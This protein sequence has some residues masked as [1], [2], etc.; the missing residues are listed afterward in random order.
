[1]SSSAKERIP[2]LSKSRFMAGLQCHK[3]LY[4]ECY[5]RDLADP[6]SAQQQSLFDTG[7]EVGTLARKLYPGGVL[8][9][10]DYFNHSAAVESTKT[11]L[12]DHKIPA[13]Y[14]AA[15]KYDNIR[16]R[17]DILVRA[18]SD[19]FDLVEI[20]SGTQTKEEHVPD[21]AVQL[22]VLN[23]CGINIRRTCL[24]H[25]NRDYTYQGGD[26][27][28]DQ[29][30]SLDDI[31]G[32]AQ[33]MQS[34]IPL[35]L[36]EMRT[37]LWGMEPPDIDTGRQCAHPYTCSF[38]GHCHANEPE[39]H[40]SQLPRACQGL[41]RT[42]KEAGIEDIR[43]IP[44]NFVE[45]TA[46]QKRVQDCVVH[47]RFYLDRQLPLA[48]QQLDYPIHFLDFETLSP[49][50]P[51]Y[52]GTRPY[53]V[54]P[55]QWSD[56]ILERDEN[57]RH[58]EFLHEGT[59]DPREAFTTSLLNVLGSEGSI[60]VY[61]GFE[62][63]RIRELADTFPKLANELLSLEE[64]RIVD[65]LQLIRRYCYHKEFHGSFS[66]KSVLPALVPGMSYDDLEINDGGMAPIAYAEMIHPD[67]LSERRN[68]LK[69]SLLAYCSRDT[70]A[71]VQLFKKLQRAFSLF[72]SFSSSRPDS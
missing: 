43:D 42:L 72:P 70:E 33:K 4:F 50:L 62:A 69:R 66:I 13:L 14:E 61:S 1:M 8:I 2:L 44:N 51:L 52:I 6:V 32:E 57:L 31:T 47:N 37:P 24:G 65:L 16:I 68:F 7:T 36:T 11:V 59:D 64:A 18:G 19:Y 55:F 10:E 29:L 12:A 21:V 9:E 22:Y 53:Q 34:D 60:V 46:L 71:E 41:L 28:L 63:I 45:L 20:K 56:H 39:H 25:L 26:Y 15:F 30:F 49:P 67:T 40:I 38:Y 54:I 17:V 48:L 23:G 5:Q 3:R 58:E 27:A 35:L